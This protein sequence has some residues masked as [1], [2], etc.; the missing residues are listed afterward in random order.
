MG[1]PSE[2]AVM[3]AGVVPEPAQRALSLSNALTAPRAR[4]GRI[5]FH[6]AT[7]VPAPLAFHVRRYRLD[8]V[9]RAVV[10]SVTVQV[11]ER[12]SIGEQDPERDAEEEQRQ[13]VSVIVSKTS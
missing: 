9:C 8:V 13:S 4:G 5:G 12:V 7:T 6:A 10:R 1:T 2:V 11:I 3:G